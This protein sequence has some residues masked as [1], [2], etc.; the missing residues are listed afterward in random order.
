MS[1]AAIGSIA[2]AGI[3]A[4][5][6]IASG[7]MQAGAAENA[8]QLQAQEAQNSLNFQEQEWNTQQQNEAPFLEAGQGAIGNLSQMVNQGN[9]G[10]GPL[11]P[12]TGTFSAPTAAQAEATPGY[13]FQAQQGEQ[14]VQ[15]S[16]AASGGLL[17]GGTLKAEQNYGQGLASENYQNTFNNALTQYQTA[18]NTF[19]NNAANAYNRE[20]GIA[21]IG[22]TAANQLGT[23]GQQAASNTANINLTTGAQQG[24]DIQNAAFQT[25]SG[26]TGAAN[27]LSGGIN[28]IGSLSMLQQILAQQQQPS[29]AAANAAM[30]YSVDENG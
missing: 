30:P 29:M 15:N 10:Q 2:A 3:G 21:G 1:V 8:Q 22:Q 11:A 6:S 5:G 26:Y 17:T 18:Y 27:A 25:A 20:A 24:A 14:A 7:S 19:Q 16:A 9:A 13:Q 23:E 28:N 4:A 12:W